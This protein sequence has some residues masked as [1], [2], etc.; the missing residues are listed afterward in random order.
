MREIVA[1]I[2][3][4]VTLWTGSHGP[5]RAIAYSPAWVYVQT[6]GIPSTWDV[7]GALTFVDRYTGRTTFRRATCPAKTKCIT[8]KAGDV[9][10]DLVGWTDPTTMHTE[11][12]W[13]GAMRTWTTTTITVDLEKAEQKEFDAATRKWL[14]A[15]E[16]GHWAGL[17]HQDTRVSFMYPYIPA[18]PLVT[19]AAE[20][21]QLAGR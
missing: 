5:V 11:Q 7:I 9:S 6:V 4:G 12:T 19:T 14:L 13:D 17:P 18:P 1:A 15:H 20:R 16:V 10:G 21:Q 2:I 3:A 8:I